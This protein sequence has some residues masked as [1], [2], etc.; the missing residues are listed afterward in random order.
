MRP[1]NPVLDLFLRLV[2]AFEVVLYL[3]A[4]LLHLGLQIPLGSV[5]LAVP[6]RILPAAIVETILGLALAA[7]FVAL[8]RANPG[9]KG[10][11]I[12]IHL[13][14]VAGVLLGMLALALRVGPPP[15]PHW[16]IHYVMLGA[17]AVI[18][19]LMLILR[20]SGQVDPVQP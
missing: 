15:G 6:D 2:V 14:V 7:N 11:T 10:I 9:W 8:T 17:L 1:S 3:V 12:G 19:L 13:I 5:T 20:K 16:T 18:A 4:A